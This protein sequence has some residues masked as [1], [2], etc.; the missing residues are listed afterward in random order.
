VAYRL[1]LDEPIGAAV[2]ATLDERVA[3]AV[4]Q[5][6]ET[7]AQDRT[8]A[9]HDAR[10]DL[11]KLR[12][13][14]RL[15]GPGVK[16]RERRRENTVFAEVGRSLSVARDADVMVEVV[17]DLAARATGQVPEATFVALRQALSDAAQDI[18]GA[19]DDATLE[20]AASELEAARERLSAWALDKLHDASLMEGMAR[21][22]ARGRAD[23]AVAQEPDP[24]AEHLH[25]WRKRVKDLWYQQR[26]LR[27]V[28]PDVM[29]AQIDEL[30]QLA[31]LLGDDHDLFVLG[32]LLR[33]GEGAAARVPADLD[34]LIAAI[35]LRRAGILT[36]ARSIGRRVYAE[37]PEAFERRHAAYLA[38]ARADRVPSASLPA[39]SP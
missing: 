25:E 1:N 17:D 10:K 16:R 18:Q 4:A 13:L 27:D 36:A 3:H 35:D 37:K 21:G 11:K 19:V 32:E 14:L 22:Y 12:S 5:L 34:P 23:L 6:R 39:P 7:A 15:I 2:A 33:S 26:L 30:D 38:A 28:W 29:R 24:T 20:A 8:S 31:K 9:I